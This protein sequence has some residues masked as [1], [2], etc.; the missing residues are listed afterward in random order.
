MF[1]HVN[2]TSQ[3]KPKPNCPSISRCSREDKTGKRASASSCKAANADGSAF[4]SSLLHPFLRALCIQKCIH[5]H[6]ARC[7]GRALQT[8][9]E[10]LPERNYWKRFKL[11]VSPRE[12]S[13]SSDAR[14]RY[15]K[16]GSSPSS[17]LVCILHRLNTLASDI[18]WAMGHRA[19]D[20]ENMANLKCH[21]HARTSWKGSI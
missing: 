19:L 17:R 16:K 18:C 6:A 1:S 7:H 3:P 2:R 9:F 5:H 10:R 21:K 20:N 13:S 12:S 11:I 4:F 15:C 8:F 14:S